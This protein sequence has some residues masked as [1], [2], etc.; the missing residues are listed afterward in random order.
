[1]GK[2]EFLT[3]DLTPKAA[4]R[5]YVAGYCNLWQEDQDPAEAIAEAVAACAAPRHVKEA[6]K[7]NVTKLRS[8]E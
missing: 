1:M 6:E 4:E 8:P 3:K 2:T 7:R 5:G